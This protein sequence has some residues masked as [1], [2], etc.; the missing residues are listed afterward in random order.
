MS[1]F[2]NNSEKR[3]EQLLAFSLG[4]MNGEDVRELIEKYSSAVTHVTPHDMLKLEDRQMQMGITPEAIKKDVEKVINVFYK[5]LK[6]YQWEKPK[7][8]TFLY[9]LMLENSAFTYRLNKVK[10]ILKSYKGRESID[11]SKLKNELLPHFKEFLAFEHHYVKKENI[12]FPYLEKTW[13]N[14]RPLNVMWSL[15]DDIRALLKK[16]LGMLEDEKSRW[17][18]F[19][20]LLGKYYFM[21][22]GMMQKEDLIVYPV[23]AE[24]VDTNAWDEMHRQS[25]EYPF[26]FIDPPK[27]PEENSKQSGTK[28]IS[29]ELPE[30]RGIRSETGFMTIE[31]ALLIFNNLPVDITFVDENDRV[32]FFNRAKE[33]FFPRS[34]AIIGRSVQ[35][36]HPPESVHVVE[37]IV[38][39]FRSGE[40]NQADFWIQ[41]KGKF[42]LIQYYAIR[43]EQD[44][45]KGVLEVS[46]DVTGIRNLEGEK[47]LLEW[48]KD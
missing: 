12:L 27:K 13:E 34:P 23:A 14:Y 35:N 33:R 11:F 1:E 44:E 28:A 38:K 16:L 32:R 9:Y 43:N 21:V 31:Q 5:N 48:Q 42:I 37:E 29:E 45:Y 46:Q 25:F 19:S 20:K 8:G 36:C 24:T 41:M 2:I 15:H 6:N 30:N 3:V 40:K 26:P 4:V 18:D 22:F 10:K 39:T 7:E 47:R 17:K